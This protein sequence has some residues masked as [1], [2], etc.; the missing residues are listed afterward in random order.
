MKEILAVYVNDN[1]EY[2][3]NNEDIYVVYNSKNETIYTSS[4]VENAFIYAIE[5]GKTI[6]KGNCKVHYLE[7]NEILLFSDYCLI[8]TIKE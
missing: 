1:K 5:A 6:G 2:Y 3:V 8:L 4:L 7:E